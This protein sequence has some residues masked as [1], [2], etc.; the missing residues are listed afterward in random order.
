MCAFG[1]FVSLSDRR[2]RIGAP[3]APAGRAGGGVGPPRA[4]SPC[5]GAPPAMNSRLLFFLPLLTL[6]LMAG[7]FAWSLRLGPRSGG[8]RL[9]AG[10]PFGAA[11][12]RA[13]LRGRAAGS[14]TRC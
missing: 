1:G 6:A 4:T 3:D 2:L 11:L 9:G 10:R 5:G 14:P 13:A 8:D 12:R 7:F